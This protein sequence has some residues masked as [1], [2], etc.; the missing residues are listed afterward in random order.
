MNPLTMTHPVSNLQIPTRP[1]LWVTH[2]TMCSALGTGRPA[3]LAA[4]AAERTGLIPV[5][6]SLPFQT[7]CGIV[8]CELPAL[9]PA[10]AHHDARIT[11]LIAHLVADLGDAIPQTLS[12]WGPAR[13]GIFVGTSTAGIASTEAAWRAHV[14]TGALPPE[15][16]FAAQHSYGA[17]IP[18]IRA[19][20]GFAGPAFVTST[21]CSSSA[22]VLASATRLIHAG[23]IDAALVG[24]AD[25]LCDLTLH[26][27]HALGAL[28]A[29]PCRPFAATRDGIS[30]GE[31]GGL[32]LVA[33]DGEGRARVLAV[34]ET[35][36]AHHISAPHPEG[37]GARAA[38][39]AALAIAGVKPS[40]VGHINA[41]GT[42]TI[43]NDRAE[44]QAIEAVFG[45]DVPVL[46]TKAYTGHMLGAAGVIETALTVMALEEG[47]I[48]ASLG[49][50]P[51][52]E[53]IT[54]GIVH[55]R[56]RLDRG[57]AMTNSLAFGGSN[58]SVLLGAA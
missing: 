39:Q 25:T 14:A 31:G 37:A 50:G 47:W 41:H 12:R 58:V 33:R 55:T 45:R 52:D 19:L 26:G 32:M 18:V 23:V 38:M 4:L 2:Y 15:Y 54:I 24:G 35:N 36:D 11:R 27:F 5:Q 17:I 6:G 3:H 21:A 10:L 1:A 51:V 13:V 53:A 16:D 48:P 20:T 57:L 8:S 42:G 43:L 29:T 7:A 49:A 44:S 22:K 9:P 28:S 46:S 56:T 30:I 40:D 34:G